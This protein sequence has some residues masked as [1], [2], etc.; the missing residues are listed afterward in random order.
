MIPVTTHPASA[1]A[2]IHREER[3]SFA[4]TGLLN[5][6]NTIMG[7]ATSIS[8]LTTPCRLSLRMIPARRMITPQ[9]I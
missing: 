8:S 6:D 7:M 2:M 5:A 4:V 9:S 1:I 3:I